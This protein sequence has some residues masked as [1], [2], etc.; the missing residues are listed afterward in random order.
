MPA[1]CAGVGA[2][3]AGGVGDT[4]A[5]PEQPTSGKNAASSKVTKLTPKLFV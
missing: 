3:T 1:I 4:G 5:G 2:T